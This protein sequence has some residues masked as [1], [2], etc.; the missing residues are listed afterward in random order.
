MKN[1]NLFT[2]NQTLKTS[3]K[4][5]LNKYVSYQKIRFSNF[6]T[7]GIYDWTPY[8]DKMFKNL[9]FK[10]KSVL[11]VGPGDGFFLLYFRSKGAKVFANE[12]KSQNERDNY[13]FGELNKKYDSDGNIRI[14]KSTKKQSEDFSIK[15]IYKTLTHKNIKVYNYNIYELSKINKKFDYVFC[16]DVFL[17]LTDPLRALYEL[18]Q[19]AKYILLGNCLATPLDFNSSIEKLKYKFI[20]R[21]SSGE[22]SSNGIFANQI[23]KFYNQVPLKIFLGNT[24]KN[25][26]YFPNYKAINDMII[27]S[28]LKIISSKII[29]PAKV[30]FLSIRPRCISLIKT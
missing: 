11:D 13:K 18:K 28:G 26:F 5:I 1:N 2:F 8:I 3:Q 12:I 4:K 27:S 7:N 15:K 10:K 20:S 14:K 16:N 6:T 22:V 25:A 9:N 30:D 29:N 24:K 19:V 23:K 21:I 17:H